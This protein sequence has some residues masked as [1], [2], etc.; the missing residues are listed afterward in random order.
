MDIFKLREVVEQ[1][2]ETYENYMAILTAVEQLISSQNSG[3]ANVRSSAE[4][5]KEVRHKAIDLV[6]E[7]T[8]VWNEAG[9][10]IPQLYVDRIERDIMNIRLD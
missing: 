1:N 10:K 5:S 8:S 2:T 4:V 6:L 9:F 7:I 3:E